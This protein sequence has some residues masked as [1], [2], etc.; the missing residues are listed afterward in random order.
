MSDNKEK[1]DC[2]KEINKQFYD[3][4]K[5]LR[6]RKFAQSSRLA[7]RAYEIFMKEVFQKS[8]HGHLN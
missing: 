4:I 8:G 6:Q 1:T 7:F 5:N 3:L 2:L